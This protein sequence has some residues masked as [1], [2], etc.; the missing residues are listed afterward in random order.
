MSEPPTTTER[1][2]R[3]LLEDTAGDHCST[4]FT[5]GRQTVPTT[6]PLPLPVVV[7][8]TFLTKSKGFLIQY[9]ARE[10]REAASQLEQK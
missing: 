5:Q 2:T 10:K 8:L 6:R 9:V 4:L 1:K 7:F 3:V